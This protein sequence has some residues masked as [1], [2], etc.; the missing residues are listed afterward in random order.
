ML[1][2]IRISVDHSVVAK[3]LD[4]RHRDADGRIERKHGNTKIK[5]LKEIYPE[6]KSYRNEDTLAQVR[7][8]Y[9][10]ESLDALLKEIRKK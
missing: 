1:M 10:V 6:L 9:G 4:G 3:G 8:R 7:D 5:N 2:N